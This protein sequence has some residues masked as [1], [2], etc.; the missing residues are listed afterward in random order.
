MYYYK[1]IIAVS[2]IIALPLRGEV[3][4]NPNYV[5]EIG[6]STTS[7]MTVFQGSIA[8]LGVDLL[9]VGKNLHLLPKSGE[10]KY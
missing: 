5:G 6:L 4:V 3:E 9:Q 10:T 1:F 7:Q 2:F 8:D